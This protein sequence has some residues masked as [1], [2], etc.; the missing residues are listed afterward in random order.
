MLCFGS[1]A[2]PVININI[3]FRSG[4]KE[5]TKFHP[6]AIE[7]VYTVYAY[8][9]A[10]VLSGHINLGRGPESQK[11]PA[12]EIVNHI[13]KSSSITL[14]SQ[15]QTHRYCLHKRAVAS[16]ESIYQLLLSKSITDWKNCWFYLRPRVRVLLLLLL[17]ASFHRRRRRAGKHL[18]M[19]VFLV[20]NQ[21]K[22]NSWMG[23]Y[24]RVKR[25]PVPP[26]QMSSFVLAQEG[27]EGTPRTAAAGK[28]PA[29]PP[30]PL[31]PHTHR[32]A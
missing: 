3:V 8:G 7:K 9:C 1:W 17:F 20:R 24:E 11:K 21:K 19:D 2:V 4:G 5:Y 13:K 30:P 27:W 10:N 18:L 16:I 28:T 15:K 29:L 23:Q 32:H 22:C 6:T 31:T 12:G 14:F 25:S 26:A